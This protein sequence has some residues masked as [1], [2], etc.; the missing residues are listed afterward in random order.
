MS[1]RFVSPEPPPNEY[2]REV[3]N[4]LIEECAEII[5]R[6]TKMLRFGVHEVQPGQPLSNR[7]RLSDEIGDFQAVLQLAEKANLVDVPAI[8]AGRQRKHYRLKKYM[9]TEPV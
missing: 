2:E 6:A 4:N 9:Q 5:Q 7:I 3:L 1:D 8:E